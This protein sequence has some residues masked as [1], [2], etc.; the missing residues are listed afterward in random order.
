MNELSGRVEERWEVK[1]RQVIGRNSKIFDCGSIKVLASLT[2]QFSMCCIEHMSDTQLPQAKS[3]VGHKPDSHFNHCASNN[4]DRYAELN[5]G[6]D[7]YISPRYRFGHTSSQW[8][9]ERGAE[10]KTSSSSWTDGINHVV[11]VHFS[12]SSASVSLP[13]FCSESCEWHVISVTASEIGF[14]SVISRLA[15]V[16]CLCLAFYCCLIV[17]CRIIRALTV[18]NRC[19]SLEHTPGQTLYLLNCISSLYTYSLYLIKS[20]YTIKEIPKTNPFTLF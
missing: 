19:Y 15:G 14:P 6:Q 4:S 7:T 5:N 16:N 1:C 12:S 10:C 18:K 9:Q 2:A 11:F 8:R 13:F 20:K 3:V 17:Y